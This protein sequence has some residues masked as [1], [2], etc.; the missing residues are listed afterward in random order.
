MVRKEFSSVAFKEKLDK[1]NLK[2]FPAVNQLFF[3]F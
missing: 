2:N 1:K 3:S